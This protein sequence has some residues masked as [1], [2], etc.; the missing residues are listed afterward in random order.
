MFLQSVQSLCALLSSNFFVRA[1]RL[2]FVSE[3]LEEYQNFDHPWSPKFQIFC[4][5]FSFFWIYCS[6]GCRGTPELLTFLIHD[7]YGETTEA[8]SATPPCVPCTVRSS[9]T[10]ASNALPSRTVVSAPHSTVATI[11]W[12]R[13]DFAPALLVRLGVCTATRNMYLAGRLIAV[14]YC[15][16][17]LHLRFITV[18][19]TLRGG[20][21][22]ERWTSSR[23][24]AHHHHAPSNPME[25]DATPWINSSRS[26]LI[27]S[28]LLPLSRYLS[29]PSNG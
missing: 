28:W 18:V 10:A 20:V 21:S 7:W 3:N 25:L 27:A 13:F 17:A 1:P 23:R 26:K 15:L 24:R 22:P 19:M 12:C 9:S 2:L 4:F 11:L 8:T 6:W 5:F 29:L 16:A 14:C